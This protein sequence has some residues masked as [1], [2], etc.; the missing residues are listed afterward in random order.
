MVR[1]AGTRLLSAVLIGADHSDESLGAP[2]APQP[3]PDNVIYW[4]N[5][6]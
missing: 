6:S 1:L 3:T 2:P 5:R 4:Q